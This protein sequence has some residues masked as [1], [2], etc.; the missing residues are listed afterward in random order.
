MPSSNRVGLT[1]NFETT[2]DGLSSHCPFCPQLNRV[3][4]VKGRWFCY[5]VCQHYLE[6]HDGAIHFWHEADESE[7]H[8]ACQAD[9]FPSPSSAV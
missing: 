9:C 8:E 7:Q 2:V 1:F 5:E 4:F 6:V 3:L